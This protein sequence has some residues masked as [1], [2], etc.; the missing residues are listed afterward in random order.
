[1]IVISIIEAKLSGDQ[2][3]YWTKHNELVEVAKRLNK[4][5]AELAALIGCSRSMVAM[6]MAKKTPMSLSML[7]KWQ[8]GLGID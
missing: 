7:I 1:M 6:V 5:Q 3:A 2:E 4:T 8:N